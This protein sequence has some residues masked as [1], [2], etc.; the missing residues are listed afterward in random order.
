M[1]GNY[2]KNGNKHTLRIRNTFYFSTTTMVTRTCL[3]VTLYV[4]CL[5]C[6]QPTTSWKWQPL[7]TPQLAQLQCRQLLQIKTV[8]KWKWLPLSSSLPGQGDFWDM[9]HAFL[10]TALL[11]ALH[12]RTLLTRDALTDGAHTTTSSLWSDSTYH[13]RGHRYHEYWHPFWM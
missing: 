1:P 5:S 13:G 3:N 9:L 6:L 2:G 11:Q 12:S 4:H 8:C 10:G 7:P